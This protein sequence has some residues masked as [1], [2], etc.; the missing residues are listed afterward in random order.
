MAPWYL[1]SVEFFLSSKPGSCISLPQVVGLWSKRTNRY[2]SALSILQKP[3]RF[4]PFGNFKR[5]WRLH[6]LAPVGC[7]HHPWEGMVEAWMISPDCPTWTIHK[8]V[9]LR[10]WKTIWAACKEITPRNVWTLLKQVLWMR[11]CLLGQVHISWLGS[12]S[13]LRAGII[14]LPKAGGKER[15]QDARF[16]H[17]AERPEQEAWWNLYP[18]T[19]HYGLDE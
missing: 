5:S 19:V 1:C 15:I 9:L 16:L 11:Y 8:E 4:H 14:L 12:D 2:E 13:S 6:S 7:R 17:R 18:Y 3:G 10:T